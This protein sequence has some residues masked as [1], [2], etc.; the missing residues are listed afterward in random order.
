MSALVAVP[1]PV[2]SSN[3]RTRIRHER[4]CGSDKIPVRPAL[5]LAFLIPRSARGP[6][7][8]PRPVFTT[9][10][11]VSGASAR[12]IGAWPVT[13]R[14]LG[15]QAYTRSE[16]LAVLKA[17]RWGADANVGPAGQLM[18]GTWSAERG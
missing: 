1:V 10:C 12:S 18:S 2:P 14:V 6:S 3:E 7:Y 16:L 13:T 11:P 17:R 4:R 8:R 15:S 5:A 9:T